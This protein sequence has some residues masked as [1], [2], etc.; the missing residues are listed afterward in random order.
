MGA[1]RLNRPLL[2]QQREF[3]ILMDAFKATEKKW[4]AVIEQQTGTAHAQTAAEALLILKTVLH[5]I[6]PL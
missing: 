1:K 4:Q 6:T 5:L 2:Q 3:R